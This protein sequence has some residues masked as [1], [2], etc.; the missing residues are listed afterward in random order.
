MAWSPCEFAIN[1]L[2]ALKSYLKHRRKHVLRPLELYGDQV[3]LVENINST[4][5]IEIQ[6]N[7]SIRGSA[8]KNLSE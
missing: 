7:S 3:L 2:R 4:S 5:L 8:F 1:M 6:D